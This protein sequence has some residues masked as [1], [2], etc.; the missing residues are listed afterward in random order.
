MHAILGGNV[1]HEIGHAAGLYH[2]QVRL[3]RDNHVVILWGNISSS[4]HYLFQ[5]S[6]YSDGSTFNNYDYD[7]IMHYPAWAFSN[8]Q[9]ECNNGQLTKCSIMTYPTSGVSIGQRTH[10]SSGDLSTLNSIY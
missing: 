2:E 4:N 10:L 1:M 8:F 6:N 3:D 7:S 5:T 9:T